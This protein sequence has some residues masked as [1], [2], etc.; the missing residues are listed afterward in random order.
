MLVPYP[1]KLPSNY[2]YIPG[3]ETADSDEA[4]TSCIHT[5]PLFSGKSYELQISGAEEDNPRLDETH[6]FDGIYYQMSGVENDCI[7]GFYREHWEHRMVTLKITGDKWTLM[8]SKYQKGSPAEIWKFSQVN[9]YPPGTQAITIVSDNTQQMVLRVNVTAIPIPSYKPLIHHQNGTIQALQEA[10][11]QQFMTGMYIISGLLGVVCLLVIVLICLG[12]RYSKLMR[13]YNE[14]RSG[15][16]K[17]LNIVHA[18]HLEDT[19]E[20]E[21]NMGRSRGLN[22]DLWGSGSELQFNAMPFKKKYQMRSR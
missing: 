12:V 3:A 8:Q 17:E 18:P 4:T 21:V 16:I 6:R 15:I 13:H 19:E 11:D 9:I 7:Q 22:K 10:Q 1:D 20:D 14:A 5:N 2:R